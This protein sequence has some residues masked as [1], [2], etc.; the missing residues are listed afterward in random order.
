VL[1]HNHQ[2]VVSLARLLRHLS[3]LGDPATIAGTV[4][5]GIDP[6]FSVA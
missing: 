3:S 5:H 1:A 2:D 6:T 4:M